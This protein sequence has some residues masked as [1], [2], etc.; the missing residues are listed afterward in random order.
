MPEPVPV[1]PGPSRIETVRCP[2]H[3]GVVDLPDCKRCVDQIAI[4]LLLDIYA[5]ADMPLPDLASHT[6]TEE[7][8]A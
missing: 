4:D 8:S 7:T 1:V 3:V 5:D 6:D 2:D